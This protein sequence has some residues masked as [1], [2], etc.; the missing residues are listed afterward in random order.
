M[1]EAITSKIS[2]TYFQ[3]KLATK[4][5]KE[6]YEGAELKLVPEPENEYDSNAV[7]VILDNEVEQICLGYVSKEHSTLV[8]NIIKSGINLVAYYH[9]KS[10][11]KIEEGINIEYLDDYDVSFIEEIMSGDDYTGNI[12]GD[13]D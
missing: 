7:Q 9:G 1:L 3:G 12:Y 11:I 4:A 6:L 13:L 10:I 5:L 8:S 2:G